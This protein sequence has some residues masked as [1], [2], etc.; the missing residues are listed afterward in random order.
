MGDTNNSET[1]NI[2][3]L[4]ARTQVE[5]GCRIGKG[6]RI[7]GKVRL[8]S[9]TYVGDNT[10]IYGPAVI[11]KKTYI[12]PNCLLGHPDRTRLNEKIS[13]P[14]DLEMNR[15]S[16]NLVIGEECII[17]SG[18]II[19]TNV[20]LGRRAEFGHNVMIREKVKIGEDTLVGTNTV[21][22]GSCEIGRNVS[23][24]TGVYICANSTIEGAVFLGPYCVFTNDKY[25]MQKEAKLIGPTIKRGA[26]IGANATLMAGITVGEGA[27]VG[28]ETL[29][30][31]DVPARTIC[32][33]VPAK[34][35]E[36]L[37]DD[38][39]SLLESRGKRE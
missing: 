9:R 32:V 1:S 12:G 8:T 22:D 15:D 26:S 23:I 39:H 20:E 37:P 17:R 7:Y 13:S 21:I 3:Y 10:I 31:R 33:G 28:A 25:A 19:Y 30:N 34:I 14:R 5:K 16:D 27:V 18:S 36:P 6:C 11:G 35:K 29:V 24:Q 38:W 2:S 4:D